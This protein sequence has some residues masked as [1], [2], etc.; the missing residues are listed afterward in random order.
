M[1]VW[2]VL[3]ARTAG[4]RLSGRPGMLTVAVQKVTQAG[5]GHVAWSEE[6]VLALVPDAAAAKAARTQAAA[7]RWT[8]AGASQVALWGYCQGSGATPYQ[9]CVDL[10][11][12]AAFR[13]TC[14]SRRFPCKHAVGLLLRWSTGAL[15]DAPVPDW[16]GAWLA[17]R[18]ARA[19]RAATRRE[20]GP[21]DPDAAARAAGKRQERRAE[22]V[23]AGVAELGEWLADQIRHGLSGLAGNA[24]EP[25]R[26]A[27]A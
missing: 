13:C 11:E 10:A 23:A 14:P 15:P 9:V 21:A 25:L 4:D 19:E 1:P 5:V 6:R 8:G 27:A 20:S 12:P 16:I 24:A 2:A 22:R 17:E 18:A 7:T 26:S 3:H